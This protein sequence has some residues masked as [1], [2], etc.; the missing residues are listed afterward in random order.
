MSVC[1]PDSVPVCSSVCVCARP[2]VRAISLHSHFQIF[3]MCLLDVAEE[4][5]SW[6]TLLLAESPSFGSKY[7]SVLMKR[8]QYSL[9]TS[10]KERMS[11]EVD[12]LSCYT[13]H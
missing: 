6:L 13:S 1:V 9:R 12:H 11:P 7:I 5:N 10:L 4:Q 8:T 3:S 2:V